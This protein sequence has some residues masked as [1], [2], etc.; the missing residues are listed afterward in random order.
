V[1]FVLL[2]Q[3][4]QAH[5]RVSGAVLGLARSGGHAVGRGLVEPGGEDFAKTVPERVA[6]RTGFHGGVVAVSN[7]MRQR[8]GL[9]RDNV[10]EPERR[11]L[12]VFVRFRRGVVR[13]RYRGE[14]NH[15]ERQ[16]DRCVSGVRASRSHARDARLSC[17]AIPWCA[18]ALATGWFASRA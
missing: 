7:G 3:E 1:S 11:V 17:G 8:V 9:V 14:T 2:R 16:R 18:F 12:P 10:R 15:L 4:Q 13:E 6:G 5:E